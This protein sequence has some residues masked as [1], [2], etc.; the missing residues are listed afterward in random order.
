MGNNNF[1]EKRRIFPSITTTYNSNWK[2]KIREA[3][4][5]NLKEVCL[6]LTCLEKKER[7]EFYKM[8][9]ETEIEKSPL[10]HARSDMTKEELG[11]LKENYKVEAFNIHSQKEYPLIEDW[12]EF[13]QIT[14]IENT[15]VFL[16]PEDIK[17]FAGVC[18]DISHLEYRKI[19]DPTL[20]KNFINIA[21][22]FYCGCNHISCAKD[23]EL[24]KKG[25]P[26]EKLHY[27]ES[28]SEM[29]YLKKYSSKYFSSIIAIELENSLR[30]QLEVRDYV[31]ELLK[32]K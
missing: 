15:S 1:W 4:E 2:E 24:L 31:V 22:N 7:E 6:F 32:D 23:P 13:K 27:L 26:G 18:L 28:L 21:N 9:K 17:E 3:E 11:Y 30:E 12:G 14:Y 25:L 29:D 20:Y 10:V 16:E 19:I 5:L 8:L